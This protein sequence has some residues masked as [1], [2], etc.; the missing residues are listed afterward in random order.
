MFERFEVHCGYSLKQLFKTGSYAQRYIKHAGEPA[1][2]MRVVANEHE[3]ERLLASAGRTN[4]P[5]YDLLLLLVDSAHQ[6][7]NIT[8]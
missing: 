3:M 5:Q 4:H 2:P 1:L 6:G 7:F 8:I